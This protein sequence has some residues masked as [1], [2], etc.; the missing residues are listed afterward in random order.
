[1]RVSQGGVSVWYGTP[2]APAPSGVVAEDGDTSVTVGLQPPDPVA[3]IMVLYRINHGAPRT[4]AAQPTHHDPSGKQYFRAQLTGFKN[5]DEVEYVAIY[6]S[7]LRQ[8]PSLQEAESHVATFT[9]GPPGGAHATVGHAEAQHHGPE[10]EDLKQ[11]LHAVL[12]AAS[13]LNSA[14]LEESFVKLYFSHSGDAQSFWQELGKHSD[15]KPHVEQLQFALQ[16]DLL[17][18][19]HLP[20]IE[21]LVKMPGVK[22]MQDLAQLDDSVWHGLIAKTGAPH[23]IP[24]ASHEV[25]ARFYA[26]SILATLQAGFPTMTVRRIAARSHRVDPL[27]VK[28]LEN[29]PAF[30]MRTTRV[31][32]HADQHPDTAFK[33][34]P[35]AKRASA[36]KDVK[37]IQRL[38]AASANADAF[39]ALLDTELN[40]AHAMAA[41]PRATFIA[42]YG[43]ILGGNAAAAEVHERAQFINARNVHLRTS[44][45]DAIHTPPT[46]GLGHH[47]H[48]EMARTYAT[49]KL[50]LC[51][52]LPSQAVPGHAVPGHTPAPHLGLKAGSLKEDLIKQFPNSEALF[53]SISLC[54]CEEC[55]SAI[56]PAAYLVDVLDFLGNSDRNEHGVSPL[57]ILIGNP[58][59]KIPGRR[60]DLAFLNLT[61]ANTNTTMP[62]IDIV[63]EILESYVALGLKLDG[64]SA[65][66]SANSTSDELNANP[67]YINQRAY[68]LLEQAVYPFSLPFNRPLLVA[69]SYLNQL[70]A[71]R[72]DLLRTF[73]KDRSSPTVRHL[74]AAEFLGVSAEEFQILTGH[75]FDP[76]AKTPVR[77]DAE[78]YG[79]HGVPTAHHAGVL[80]SDSAS[81]VH[82]LANVATFQQRTGLSHSE[83]RALVSTLF[84]SP[85]QPVG[86]AKDILQR[87][88]V[89][90][91]AL[92]ALLKSNLAH[93][94]EALVAIELA[95]ISAHDLNALKAD[96]FD[97]IGKTIVIDDE[98]GS[99][100]PASMTLRH[101][102]GTEIDAPA[103]GRMHKFI[104]LYRKTGWTI[105]D[106]DRATSAFLGGSDITPD[107]LVHLS[108]VR[109]LQDRLHTKNVQILLA[110]WAPMDTQGSNSLYRD[111]FLNKAVHHQGVDPAF[112]Q[113]FPDI[114]VLTNKEETLLPHLP[115]LQSA[116]R[117]TALDMGLILED[118]GLEAAST[119]LD[120]KN[121]SALYRRAALAKA[122]K[123]KVKDFLS[124]KAV[125]GKDPFA[126]PEETMHF[127][128]IVA[129]AAGSSLTPAQLG[130]IVRHAMGS[131]K[132]ENEPHQATILGLARDLRDGLTA[133]ARDNVFAPDPNGSVTGQKLSLLFDS[134]V[135]D[136]IIGIING[137]V[138]YSAPLIVLPSG[139]V[140]PA[141]LANKIA[142]DP[143]AQ[144][145]TCKSPLTAADRSV[146]FALS[147]DPAFHASV[148]S[149]YQEPLEMIKTVLG[150]FL[151]PDEAQKKLVTE[152]GSLGADLNPIQLDSQGHMTTDPAQARK[153]AIADKFEYVLRGLLPHLIVALGAALLKRTISES[154]AISDLMTQKLL[155]TLLNSRLDSSRKAA[156]DLHSLQTP[157]LTVALYTSPDQ[158][159]TKTAQIDPV[160]AWDGT[161]K[162]LPTGTKSAFWTGMIAPQGSGDFEFVLR[163][164]GTPMVWAGDSSTPMELV[165]SSPGEWISKK[166]SLKARQLYYFR[167]D[168]S[169]LPDA[170]PSMSLLWQSLTVHKSI[171]P[172][173]CLYPSSVLDAFRDTYVLLH[174]A[175]L[176][177]NALKLNEN[178]VIFL[179]QTDGGLPPLDL[180]GLPVSRSESTS[181]AIDE[182]APK[183]FAALLR[184]AQLVIF[185]RDLPVSDFKL[186]QLFDASSLEHA[187]ELLVSLTGWDAGLVGDLAKGFELTLPDFRNEQWPFRLKDCVR[188]SDRLGVSPKYLFDWSSTSS[189]FAKL[190]TIGQ[191]IKKCVQGQYDEA[192]WLTVAKPLNDKLRDAQ[193]NALIA[194]LLPRMS[195]KDSDQLFEVL[196]IDAEM[197]ICTE[198]SR[199]SLAHSSV[200]LFVQRCLMNLEDTGENTSVKPHQID[201]DQWEKWRKH[202]RIWQANYQVLLHPENWMEQGLRDDKTPFFKALE[203]DL[204]QQDIT[205][206]NVET[207]YLNYLEKLQQ[208]ARLEI[209]GTFWQDKDPETHDQ[210]NILHVFGRT[211]HSPHTYFYR[212]LVNF[213]TWT[214]WEEMQV[215]IEGD[216]VMPMIWNRRLYV[217]WPT[218]LK[219]T[220]PPDHPPSI[221]PTSK[222]IP[223]LDPP[224]HW[225]VSLAWTELRHNKW[226]AKQVSKNAFDIDPQFFVPDD[227]NRYAKYAYSFKTAIATQP[228]GTPVSL[229]FRCVF[230]GPTVF[231]IPLIGFV[232]LGVDTTEVVGAF[233]VGGCNGE[234]VEAHSGRM[235]WPNPITPPG[236]NVEALTYVLHPGK[237]GL[238]LT[239]AANQQPASFLKASPTAYRLLYPHQFADYLLQAPL[240]YQDKH[241]TFFVTPQEEHGPV[242]QVRSVSH[243]AFHR[244]SGAG[245][246]RAKTAAA[247]TATAV[248]HS[249]AH[250]SSRPPLRPAPGDVSTA[251]MAME[252]TLADIGAPFGRHASVRSSA[253][254]SHAVSHNTHPPTATK[255]KFETFYHPYVCEFM[256]AVTRLGINGLLTVHNQSLGSS[257]R[258]YFA[259][260]YKPTEHVLHP[261]PVDTVDF[262]H[263]PYAIYNQELFFH[264]PDLIHERLHQN[265]RYYD[266]IRWLQYIFDPTDDGQPRA[267]PGQH[268]APSGQHEPPP[269][270]YW[271]YLPFKTSPRDS[272]QQLLA[273]MESG[274]EKHSQ[275]ISDW[276]QHPFQPYAI[277]R[278]RLE[279]YKKN[280]F[281]K[282]VR[283]LI[284]HGDTLF[285]SDS[286]EAINE[287]Q[288]L[289]IMAAH[290]LGPKPEK[291]PPQSKPKPECYA[292]LRGKL[293]T[294]AEG[295]TLLENEYPFSGKV[296]GH[297]KA[298]SGGLQN[299]GRTL[300]FC[301]PQ[302]AKL[303]ELWDIVAD[304]LYKIRNCLNIEGVFRQL[305]LF[306][307]PI[308]PGMLVR[309]AALGIDLGSLMGDIQAPLPA[310]RFSYMLQKA[311]E[312]CNECRSFGGA[313]LSAL[314]KNDAEALAVMRATHEVGILDLM[315]GVK[316]RQV[317]EANAQVTALTA[318]RNTA[319][320]RY[321][322]Y[323]TLMG[324]SN[325]ATPDPGATIPLVPIPSQ[326]AADVFGI[327]LIPEEGLEL[328]L[329]TAASVIQTVAGGT[330]ALA[331][332]MYVIPQINAHVQPMGVGATAG[333]GGQQFGH[334]VE[335]G[336]NTLKIVGEVLAMAGTLSG[337]MGT[338]FRRQADWALQNNL[339]ACEIMQI[340]KQI[341][342][343][344]IRV[345]IAQR[346]LTSHEKQMENSKTVLDYMTSQKF[347][348]LDLYGWMIS[349]TSSSYFACYQMAFALA[350]K[351]ERTFRFERGLT[352]SNFIQFG[353]WDSLRKGLL[354]GDRLHLAL[355]KMESA[356]TDQNTRDYEI[357]RDISL[358]LNAP[359]AL[360]ALKET[361][362]CEIAVPESFFDA[363]YPGQYMRRLKSVTL[364]VPCV[365]GPYTSLNCRLT[366][367]SNKTRVSSASGDQY[368]ENMENGDDRFV[369][370]FAAVQSIATSHGLNDAGLFEV[371]FRDE[372]YLPFEGA[373]LISRWRL[374]MPQENNAFDFETI[375]D[376]IL[377]LKYTA[378]EGGDPLRQAARQALASGPQDDLL[379]L[380]SARHEFPSDWY[381][382]LNP[383][384]GSTKGQPMAFELTA[385][386]FPFQFRGKTISIGKVDLFLSFKD[387]HDTRAY[388]QDGTPLGDYATGKP[389]TVNLTPPGGTAV[390]VKLKSDKSLLNGL[391]H[392]SADLSDQS[393]GLGAWTVD[394]QNDDLAGLPPS[395][396][397]DGGASKI[398]RI[399]PD[400]VMDLTIVCHYSVN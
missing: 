356:Y 365:V 201:A 241:S 176:L 252:K 383:S 95:G 399:K 321:G 44:I 269:Q 355:L 333:E 389:L 272:I 285:L 268:Q 281:I 384:G 177:V 247:H 40:S 15:L 26:S 83:L 27:A 391:P 142:F 382:F 195:L 229:V 390:S 242:H 341:A 275:L 282:Y 96:N 65:R 149:L 350:K 293:D 379:R 129:N 230:H 17:T 28:F 181:K 304:R 191:E 151:D 6:R 238:T 36:I 148:E 277:A 159:G 192:T 12:R 370:N 127:A 255:V 51:P 357:S 112:A 1:M 306:D 105:A 363:D 170:N 152:N 157:G 85:N 20:L 164:N 109:Q 124:L 103:L 294:F 212:T 121:V 325:A 139:M 265:K 393:A 360:I 70:G 316:I 338:F 64:S 53:G 92:A 368:P 301:A 337:K 113:D 309:A 234:S 310:Y 248:S 320:Q 377:H 117:I 2:D 260:H 314:E 158:T 120:L 264:I 367:L 138:R 354:A 100:D 381:R 274:D 225:Q 359:L 54:D 220:P 154:L 22:S 280:I 79:Y 216:H 172:D 122:L 69:R 114:P 198:T 219:K 46:R 345:E 287:A 167:L 144:L 104:R 270:R 111:L 63:N 19:G 335:G 358:L 55:E 236:T 221:D 231:F 37:R 329:S 308:D 97:R 364:S 162:P 89:S 145:L 258:D 166:I 150:S 323:Q 289:Y 185:R 330:Q 395:L 50:S 235:H 156:H 137:A 183:L 353:Y 141:Q 9:L 305:A 266:A 56:G 346:E 107:L 332:I 81:W 348:N 317:D 190:E 76:H 290:L 284:D 206:E 209:I 169:H 4:V 168:V 223:V 400:A 21:A 45:H 184:A 232:P 58:E 291:I 34:I 344:N 194:Y 249:Q 388:S 161:K 16:I 207:A 226:S 218:F 94:T 134:G 396:R 204:T 47:S 182:R 240:F 327:Q 62:Y 49:H 253:W 115:I 123:L 153:S 376:A 130:Y 118:C 119:H 213:T 72:H 312:M 256:K 297:P 397:S 101:F 57:D 343:A 140:F 224:S 233:E 135:V 286:K 311:L 318:S 178:E 369:N 202:F 340:D 39:R 147:N 11:A 84:I 257:N 324:V 203:A 283:T 319:A 32:A 189:E 299:M 197:G 276:A 315:H 200:Q 128:T 334:V 108:H 362:V 378:R 288:Q 239:K 193:R 179:T 73:H 110:L 187:L 375:S 271:K 371:N 273:V 380:F 60:P 25:Q 210:V 99:C 132:G 155:D 214:P 71:S 171:V 392:A 102:D 313:L 336:T 342:A 116:F 13:P 10:A 215:T 52:P 136:G 279:A 374:E 146:L 174:K 18:S 29:S 262:E 59:K 372:R 339:A 3:S 31:D 278:H 173:D 75:D 267:L 263:G 35:E 24:G 385:A 361:G 66:D 87:I 322:Y 38:F 259:H 349:D 131:G 93:P 67:Q 303:L 196:L 307:P 77:P 398:Y 126:S 5:G 90:H 228:D 328:V 243:A 133:I 217:F 237:Q 43:R 42:Q 165:Q 300:Y 188:L 14:A 175:S 331:S 394:V 250:G 61:C 68:E 88:P 7:G 78:F 373:G 82:E 143:I 160:V 302:N 347:T 33:G 91:S 199:I 106:L 386:R 74:L 23:Q 298:D 387:I 180:N 295:L 351:A 205:A 245:A 186:T 211:F 8:I 244:S 30:D 125:S 86:A 98:R 352:D 261:L 208:V 246:A 296:T 227:P 251:L 222:S 41:I 326:P 366:L 254:G 163:T 292:S 48:T 80:L